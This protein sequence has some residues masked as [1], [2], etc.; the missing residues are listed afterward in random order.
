MPKYQSEQNSVGLA[1]TPTASLSSTSVPAIS[2][3]LPS[4]VDLK[5]RVW[6]AVFETEIHTKN[7]VSDYDKYSHLIPRLP[8][9]FL[10]VIEHVILN[11][12]AE[13]N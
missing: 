13:G 1:N 3:N 7:V 9:E 10:E 12:P 11:P 8:Q 6:F 4:F 5:S 2:L